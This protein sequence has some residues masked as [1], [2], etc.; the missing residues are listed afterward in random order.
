[1]A[2]ICFTN[3][4]GILSRSLVQKIETHMCRLKENDGTRTAG[5]C[6]EVCLYRGQ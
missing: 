3:E 5:V 6:L 1:M 4:A 2:A